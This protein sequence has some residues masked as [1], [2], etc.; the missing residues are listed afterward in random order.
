M[1]IFLVLYYKSFLNLILT[2]NLCNGKHVPLYMQSK[3]VP[4]ES[5]DLGYYE[6]FIQIKILRICGFKNF[7]AQPKKRKKKSS[8][9]SQ[10]DPLF[11]I[12]IF[13]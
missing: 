6:E 1:T 2:A 8:S 4:Q 7:L 13:N 3:L 5:K 10:I 11:V 9:I 12:Y